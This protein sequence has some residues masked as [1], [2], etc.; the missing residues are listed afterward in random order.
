MTDIGCGPGH[1]AELLNHQERN[2]TYTGIDYSC[3]AIEMAKR[4]ALPGN[5]QFIIKDAHM[6]RRFGNVVVML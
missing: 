3:V 2:I 5:Y 1:F 4:K 6:V